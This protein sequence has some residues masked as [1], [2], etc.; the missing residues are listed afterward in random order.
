MLKILTLN[1]GNPSIE[2]AKR[3]IE[4][5]ESRDE[6]I[7]VLT[8]TKNSVGCNYI[9]EYFKYYGSSLFSLNAQQKYYVHFPKSTTG[10]LGVMIISKLPIHARNS[11]FRDDDHFFSRFT[12]CDVIHEGIRYNLVGIYIPSRDRSEN[13]IE[14]KKKFCSAM[15]EYIKELNTADHVIVCGDFNIVSRNHIP[16]YSSFFDW[17]YRFYDF[18]CSHGFLD[19]YDFMHPSEPDYTWVGRTQSGYRYD[20]F[21]SSNDIRNRIKACNIFHETRQCSLTDHS[22]VSIEID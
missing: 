8:E 9:E 11:I 5:I 20:Y 15:A 10:D 1:I 18:F 4:W 12:S 6:D 13:K 3:Q 7:F 19:V 14:R 17:E 16:H 2:R 21:F 22:A